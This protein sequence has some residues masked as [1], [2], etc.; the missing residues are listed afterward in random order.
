M[1]ASDRLLPPEPL[2]SHLAPPSTPHKISADTWLVPRL[3]PAGPEGFVYLNSLVIR[4]REPVIVDTGALVHRDDWQR[5]VFTLVDPDDVRWVFISHEDA[6][7]VGNL[8]LVLEMCPNATVVTEFLAAMK[9][10]VMLGLPPTR[11]RWLNPGEALDAGDRELVAVRPPVFDSAGTRGLF[12]PT[13]GVLWAADAFAG[14][15]PELLY[16]ASDLPAGMWAATFARMNSLENPWHAWLDPAR[17]AEHVGDVA[18]LP[19]TAI[20]SCHGPVLRG[21]FIR[22]AFAMLHQLA[23]EPAAQAPGQPTLDAIV[24]AAMAAAAASPAYV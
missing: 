13:T 8:P 15:T 7:H 20:A 17:Y 23:G 22:D 18:T 21:G 6:D 11:C 10:G 12:D 4:G 16:E 19:L 14:P 3:A 1:T 9:L 24:A 5:D 2:V